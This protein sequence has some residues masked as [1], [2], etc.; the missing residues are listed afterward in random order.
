MR[1]VWGLL[2]LAAVPMLMGWAGESDIK[3]GHEARYR[4]AL[5]HCD[6]AREA[7]R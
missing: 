6:A 2:G 4:A 1:L 3:S 7:G 5:S